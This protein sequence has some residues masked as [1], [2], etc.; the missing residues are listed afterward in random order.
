MPNFTVSI[1]NTRA[2][3][4]T[5]TAFATILFTLFS[6]NGVAQQENRF[7]VQGLP[8]TFPTLSQAESALKGI[9]EFHAALRRKSS[10]L[11]SKN[12]LIHRYEVDAVSPL[13]S[14][15]KYRVERLVSSDQSFD[16]ANTALEIRGAEIYRHSPLCAPNNYEAKGDWRVCDTYTVLERTS[17]GDV[18][19]VTAFN[20]RPYDAIFRPRY[21][22]GECRESRDGLTLFRESVQTCPAN[23]HGRISSCSFDCVNPTIG[24]I[25]EQVIGKDDGCNENNKA[26]PC[27]VSSGNKYQPETDFSDNVFSFIRAY[28]SQNIIDNGFGRGWRSNFQRRL[29]VGVNVLRQES[30]SG[31]SEPWEKINGVWQGDADTDIIITEQVDGFL[32]SKS[33]GAVENYSSSGQLLSQIDANGQQTQYQY[34]ADNQLTAVNHHYGHQIRFS[35]LNDR[36]ATVTDAFG[37]VYTYEYLNDNLVAVVYPDT[38]PADVTDNPRKRYHYEDVNHPHHLTG[39]TDENGDRYATYAYDSTGKVISSEHAQTSSVMGQERIELDFQ[40]EGGQ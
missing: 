14:E 11:I 6:G 33:N 25:T 17:E 13:D 15:D 3:R 12:V 16:S 31:R 23:Y 36:V 7:T 38:T 39:I 22:D 26:N 27:N 40:T 24:T 32:L 9:D 2:A 5:V 8:G 20:R 34:N 30:G 29:I 19:S 21:L 28:N 37:A 4:F 35:Y 18:R 1:A 10:E